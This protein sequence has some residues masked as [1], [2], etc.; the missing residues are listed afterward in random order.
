MWLLES[1]CESMQARGEWGTHAL[2]A[3]ARHGSTGR[4]RSPAPHHGQSLLI[5]SPYPQ[6][7]RDIPPFLP[8]QNYKSPGASA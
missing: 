5:H 4:E 2:G 8:L 7:V 6:F 3:N 1:N